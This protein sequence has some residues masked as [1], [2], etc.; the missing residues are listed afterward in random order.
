MQIKEY[1][2]WSVDEV[3]AICNRRGL[4]TKGDSEEYDAMLS[5]V[6]R[7]PD[8]TLEDLYRV[9]ENICLHSQFQTV[10]NIMY[11]LANEVVKSGF[12]IMEDADLTAV[13]EAF[14]YDP[15]AVTVGENTTISI[16]AGKIPTPAGE[17]PEREA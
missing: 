8:P 9:A 6:R 2:T 16:S 12:E 4:Y 10:T 7:T 5:T 3:W 1:R 15:D 11:M 17:G 14:A 13:R